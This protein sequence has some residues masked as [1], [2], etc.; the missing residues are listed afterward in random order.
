MS[1]KSET[2]KKGQNN[3]PNKEQPEPRREIQP[4]RWDHEPDPVPEK[5][6]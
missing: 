3:P 5:A 6:K 1:N 2:T 4:D